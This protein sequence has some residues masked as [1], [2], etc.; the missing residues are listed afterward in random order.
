MHVVCM[1]CVDVFVCTVCT[2][3]M[4][5][6]CVLCTEYLRIFMPYHIRII[7]STHAICTDVHIHYSL[8]TYI[9][10]YVCSSGTCT[11]IP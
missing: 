5:V 4:C 10:T 6:L 3:C 1:E 11:S 2:V 9:R 7:C 8:P